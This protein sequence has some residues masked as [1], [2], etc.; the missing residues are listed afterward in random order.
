MTPQE[1]KTAFE[2]HF[3]R[4]LR[5][6]ITRATKISSSQD[7][8]AVISHIERLGAHGKRIRPY[9]VNLSYG[10]QSFNKKIVD[11]LIGIELL[12]LFA[13]IH[14]DIMDRSSVRH[15]VVTINAMHKDQHLAESYAMLAGDMVFNWAYESFLEGNRSPESIRLFTTL[16]EEVIVGQAIDAAL[17]HK[18]NFTERELRE[19]N[20]L[21]TARYTFRRPIE[22]GRSMA[23]KDAGKKYVRLG[24]NLGIIYQIDD[25]LLDI[26]G[27]ENKIG[28][29][30]FSDIESRQATLISLYLK[31]NPV[32]CR[33][34]GKH[35]S[36]QTRTALKRLIETSGVR[37]K[38]EKERTSL[39]RNTKRIINGLDD[40]R[41]WL[42][43]LD[44]VVNRDT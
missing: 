12:H 34:L 27:D 3:K 6:L 2:P 28:K 39:I 24:E 15:G 9:I 36:L 21:K 32:F 11:Q 25:D 17:P 43:F 1:F 40:S 41:A 26:F 8:N 30:T 31:D 29:Q 33:A 42:A 38:I 10:G 37:E 35:A 44:F 7:V 19:K 18:S 22:I 14:D 5:K 23:K 13:L 4:K 20:I 16:V